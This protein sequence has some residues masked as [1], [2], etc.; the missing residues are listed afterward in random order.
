MEKRHFV[1]FLILFWLV[2]T[3]SLGA[4]DI[5][6]A[7]SS[8]PNN[9]NPFY[10]TDANSQNI[11][12]LIHKSLIDLNESMQ[13]YCVLCVTFEERKDG[14]KYKIYFKLK[15]N[16]KFWDETKVDSKAIKKSVEYYKDSEI[17]SIFK[18]AFQKIKDVEIISSHEFEFVYEDFQLEHLANLVLLKIL[19]IEGEFNKE[20]ID[21]IVGIGEYKPS[22]LNELTIKLNS[23]HSDRDSLLFKVVKDETTLALKLINKE[24]DVSLASISPRKM[25]WLIENYG[26]ELKKW[27][28][29]SSNYI[30]INPNHRN[31]RLKNPKLRKALSLLIPRKDILKYK[32]KETAV[33]S[34]SIFSKAFEDMF[35]DF[36]MDPYNPKEANKLIEEIGY[37]KEGQF[38]S[39]NGQILEFDWIVSNNKN[40]IEIAT[41]IKQFFERNHVKINLIV[42]EWG[43]FMRRYK[44]GLFDLVISQW[45]GFTGPEILNFVFHSSNIS[46][47]GGNRGYYIDD[48]LDLLL[49]RAVSEKSEA[50]RNNL[51]KN[52]LKKI[53]DDYA[54][55]NLWHPKII[56]LS[57][58][59]ISGIS[60]LPNGSFLPLKNIKA[61]ACH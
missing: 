29:Q 20:K 31:E 49:D 2:L 22:I 23:T 53:N 11:N 15:D 43:N 19:K 59:C 60:P 44:K 56:W 46:P 33:V 35:V 48:N 41:V 27:E 28:V 26:K 30:Y 7:I 10:G 34:K 47:K 40:T 1:Q 55:L 32:L 39:K 24:I 38:Y 36:K 61:K 3:Q 25:E 16:L 54:Y 57:R 4:K 58:N 8:A 51:F 9:L 50:N 5:T 45:V 37:K 13:F 18:F 52:A 42:L 14:E 12:R 21:N 17:N 6:L